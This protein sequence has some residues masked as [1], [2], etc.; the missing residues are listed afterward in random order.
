MITPSRQ[1]VFRTLLSEGIHEGLFWPVW[2]YSRG[3]SETS[4]WLLNSI[5]GSVRF[6]GVDVWVKNW[7]V[8]MYGDDSI[9]GSLISIG[10]RSVVILVRGLGVVAWFM[11]AVLLFFLYVFAFPLALFGFFGSLMGVLF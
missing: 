6:F 1:L 7:F 10:V 5:R 3:L 8:P 4:L 11:A 9:A 2:W